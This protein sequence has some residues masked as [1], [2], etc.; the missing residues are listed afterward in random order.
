MREQARE[1]GTCSSC[2]VTHGDQEAV[3]GACLRSADG[4]EAEDFDEEQGAQHL[5]QE[6][7]VAPGALRGRALRPLAHAECGPAQGE[8]PGQRPGQGG[9]PAG[10]TRLAG[11]AEADAR[12]VLP[13]W[14]VR[15]CSLCNRHRTSSYNPVCLQHLCHNTGEAICCPSGICAHTVHCLHQIYSG[16]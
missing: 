3:Q 12:H 14:Q 4:E 9:R 15:P 10:A 1:V 2:W 16:P 7:P 11:V 8:V 5:P 6:G 13:V